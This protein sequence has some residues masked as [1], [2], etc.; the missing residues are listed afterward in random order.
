[1]SPSSTTRCTLSSI[2]PLTWKLCKQNTKLYKLITKLCKHITNL[3]KQKV[4]LLR[5]CQFHQG[6]NYF[7]KII[8]FTPKFKPIL[9][10]KRNVVWV[11]DIIFICR[12]NV[13]KFD[14]RRTQ[15]CLKNIL[16]FAQ[17]H[18]RRCK[19]FTTFFKHVHC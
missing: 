10:E 6:K 11:G 5:N 16:I 19:L 13:S 18:P 8:I 7:L 12:P 1:M 9:A 2:F 15:Y 4:V 14:T 3:F 17:S